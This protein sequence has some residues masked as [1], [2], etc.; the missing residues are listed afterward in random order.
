MYEHY[1]VLDLQP[2]A[3]AQEI[4]TQ[5]ERLARIYDPARF[6]DERDRALATQK[7]EEIEAVACAVQNVSLAAAA[8]G[9]GTFWSTPHMPIE[10]CTHDP[11][12]LRNQ[13]RMSR[14]RSTA[15]RSSGHS[16]D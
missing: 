12:G 3:T 10:H 7:L 13:V 4:K 1:R 8:R 14:G 9:I 6:S 15:K 11:S 2:T 16:T 5:F